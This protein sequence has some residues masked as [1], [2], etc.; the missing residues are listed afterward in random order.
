MSNPSKMESSPSPPM[1][2]HYYSI[3]GVAQPIRLLL[4]CL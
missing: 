1:V 4:N 3:R 2:L